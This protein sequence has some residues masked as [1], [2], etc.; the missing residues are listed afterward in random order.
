MSQGTGKGVTKFDK[1]D[2]HRGG[3]REDKPV[4]KRLEKSS[5]N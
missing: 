1:F 4:L 3:D 5:R 2:S